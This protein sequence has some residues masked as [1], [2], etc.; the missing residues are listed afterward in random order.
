MGY[1]ARLGEEFDPYKLPV[2]ELVE[3]VNPVEQIFSII[4]GV[5]LLIVLAWFA[6][7]GAYGWT[8]M[9]GLFQKIGAGAV[10]PL[11]CPIVPGRLD[12][13]RKA[14]VVKS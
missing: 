12:G 3:K 4:M 13:L 10:L 7:R 14:I 8:Q 9:N 6:D 2:A 11:D 5:V 1:A